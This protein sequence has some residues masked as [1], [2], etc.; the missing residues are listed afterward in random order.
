M[1]VRIFFKEKRSNRYQCKLLCTQ[2]SRLI[3]ETHFVQKDYWINNIYANFRCY[4]Y[5]IQRIYKFDTGNVPVNMKILI[6]RHMA[7][8]ILL[9]ITV[10][11]DS[12]NVCSLQFYIFFSIVRLPCRLQF[13]N[14]FSVL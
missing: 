3:F 14:E 13:F 8:R 2:I 12:N 4:R 6:P 1:F 7:L 5:A 10:R 11:N 9:S